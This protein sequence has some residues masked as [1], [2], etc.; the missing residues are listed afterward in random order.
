MNV[1]TIVQIVV[2]LILIGLILIQSRG[3]DAGGV[4]GGGS[5]TGF[6]QKRRGME[7]IIFAATILLTVSFAGLA[8]LNLVLSVS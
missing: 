7:K 8:L 3:G 4:F 6:Y 5:G 1:I 2:S